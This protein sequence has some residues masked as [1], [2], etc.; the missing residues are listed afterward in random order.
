MF[1]FVISKSALYLNCAVFGSF[2]IPLKPQPRKRR[3]EDD[4]LLIIQD[5]ATETLGKSPASGN[6]INIHQNGKEI[7]EQFERERLTNNTQQKVN[8]NY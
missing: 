2:L 4:K 7:I 8:Y 1:D 3:Q 5:D 6:N